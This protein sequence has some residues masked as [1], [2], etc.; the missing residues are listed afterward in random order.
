MYENHQILSGSNKDRIESHLI[1]IFR[2]KT[3]VIYNSTRNLVELCIYGLPKRRF[4]NNVD[5]VPLNK[6][7][8]TGDHEVLRA[9]GVEFLNRSVS[10]GFLH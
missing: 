2:N 8:R 3:W 7:R 9:Q 1:T 4:L 10:S 6:A 5:V